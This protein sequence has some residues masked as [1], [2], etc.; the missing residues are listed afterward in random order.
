VAFDAEGAGE[1]EVGLDLAEGRG[2]ALLAVVGVDEI[3][4]LLLAVGEYF[5]HSVQV[6]TRTGKGKPGYC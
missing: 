1:P 2:D 3:E 6:N 5:A 4:D